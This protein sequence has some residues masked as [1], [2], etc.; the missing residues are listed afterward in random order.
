[1]PNISACRKCLYFQEPVTASP[2]HPTP[3]SARAGAACCPMKTRWSLLLHPAF[4]QALHCSPDLRAAKSFN[5]EFLLEYSQAS[6]RCSPGLARKEWKKKW[7]KQKDVCCEVDGAITR[8]ILNDI[9]QIKSSSHLF[10][11]GQ[12]F[13]SKIKIRCFS[14]SPPFSFSSPP[15]CFTHF[16]VGESPRL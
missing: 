14:L 3:T 7:G 8:C 16:S 11:F 9:R 2:F 6:Q 13:L 10:D 4:S 1:M 15:L 5:E 12:V